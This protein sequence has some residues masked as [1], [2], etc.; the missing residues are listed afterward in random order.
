MSFNFHR[1]DAKRLVEQAIEANRPLAEK[2]GVLVRLHGEVADTAIWT[3][4]DRL[5]QVL[6]NLLSNAVKFSPSGEE[7]LVAI[8]TADNHVRVTVR[9][10]GLGIPD[11]FKTLIFEKFAQVDAT[12]ARQKGGT[13]LGLSI[14]RQTMLR[15]GGSVGHVPAPSRGTIFHVDVPRRAKQ[16]A[17]ED[18]AEES[19]QVA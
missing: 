7:V 17:P 6:T 12:D 2:F 18:A 1:A 13:G 15:L 3:D 8:E 14:V 10:H 11:E 4:A 9:D 5:I 19:V 16:S